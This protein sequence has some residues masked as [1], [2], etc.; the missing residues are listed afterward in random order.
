MVT[1][2]MFGAVAK[3]EIFFPSKVQA[4]EY[5]TSVSDNGGAVLSISQYVLDVQD[6]HEL[7]WKAKS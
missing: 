1:T 4:E 2:P 7:E 6:R 3:G 5:Q